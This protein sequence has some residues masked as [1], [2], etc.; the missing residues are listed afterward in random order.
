MRK[1]VANVSLSLRPW[2][3]RKAEGFFTVARSRW[4][5]LLAS[6]PGRQGWKE[7]VSAYWAGNRANLLLVLPFIALYLVQLAHH[8]LWQDE[9]NAWGIVVASPNLKRLFYL[10]HYEAHP[11]IWYLLLWT[12]SRVT[13]APVAMKVLEAAIGTAIYL[14]LALKSPFNRA[15][16]VL[17]FLSYFISFEYTVLSRMYGVL[18]LLTLVYA[19][20]R[21]TRPRASLV[22]ALILAAIA[23]TDMMGI[24]LCA[25][26]ISEYVYFSL[27]G[28]GPK[29]G[30]EK[31][32]LFLGAGL[33]LAALA[34]SVMTLRPARD[35]TTMNTVGIFRFALSREHLWHAV[36]SYVVLPWF[37]IAAGFPGHFW[38]P[39]PGT[40]RYLYSALLIP[41]LFGYYML[42]RRDRNLL[43]LVGFACIAGIAFS[44]LVY[45]GQMRHFGI[46]FIAF[47]VA[48]WIQKQT[49][50]AR[51]VA[52]YAFL[53]ISAV[54]GVMACIGQW[55]HPFSQAGNEARWIRQN[56]LQ[57][58]PLMG[59]YDWS[60]VSV[61][62]LLQRPIYFLDCNCKD[63]FLL[64]S[65]R[66]DGFE[67]NQLPARL[68]HAFVKIG[69]PEAILLTTLP[70][71]SAEL[72]D[73]RSRSLDV[74]PLAAF[75]GGEVDVDGPYIYDVKWEAV[76]EIKRD[77]RRGM[78]LT[79]PQNGSPVEE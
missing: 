19:R 34:V 79:A 55:N 54:G 62:E 58:L 5:N 11:A 28:M 75:P 77:G 21:A 31:R 30:V 73:I 74:R 24:L 51:S 49:R 47:L 14:F 78:L 7:M 53:V 52:S 57:N 41:V 50:P 6:V 35:I 67:W 13:A 20:C 18:L 1:K 72:A 65:T 48:L 68:Q 23:N 39:Y 61:A 25:A 10:I 27:R 44:H 70:L 66:R 40:D 46:A 37:P 64:L 59:A 33:F 16:K 60:V 17:L 38:N 63:T 43:L 12:V 45:F 26:L 56:H 69:R 76:A 4:S 42:F 15:E 3:A 8:Q 36:L 29:S 9:I 2:E 32:N 71:T 22:L